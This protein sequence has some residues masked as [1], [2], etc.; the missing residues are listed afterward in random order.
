MATILKEAAVSFNVLFPFYTIYK[1]WIKVYI[2]HLHWIWNNMS[3]N[4]H[5]HYSTQIELIMICT[6]IIT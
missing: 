6:H 4:E 1:H 3:I 5:I 2:P